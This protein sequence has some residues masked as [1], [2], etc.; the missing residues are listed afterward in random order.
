[1]NIADQI[2]HTTTRIECRDQ[3]GN[4]SSGTSF[5]FDFCKSDE[6][7]VP[8]IVTN[9]HVIEGSVIVSFTMTKL[10]DD[11][12][13]Q[14][15]EH[16]PIS[17]NRFQHRWLIHPESDVDLAVLPIAPILTELKNRNRMPYY[18]S[19]DNSIVPKDEEWKEF[20]AIEDIVMV[21]YPNGIWDVRNNLPIVRRGI[22]A[23]PAYANFDGKPQFM[24]DCACFPGS[25]GSPVFLY[26]IGAFMTKQGAI[27]LGGR[28]K[29]AGVLWGGPQYTAQG[30][31][32]VVPVPTQ[33]QSIAL[34]RI[35]NNLGYCI[36][37]EKLDAFE[38]I[39][40]DAHKFEANK[41]MVDE[42]D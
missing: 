34:S 18:V 11:D 31:I 7:V 14:Y 36:R 24:I 30:K 39:F 32:V 17:L 27:N 4:V 20:S 2:V 26:S 19:I 38:Q 35:P 1:M 42:A 8:A 29:L 37:A 16:V 6:G 25:S 33:E 41:I 40:V 13:P 9:K 28:V 12:Q 21:G 5:F 15:G 10:G 23:T 3:S 22:T